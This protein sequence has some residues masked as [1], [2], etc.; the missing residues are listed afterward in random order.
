MKSF[1]IALALL[2]LNCTNASAECREE[3]TAGVDRSQAEFNCRNLMNGEVNG[4]RNGGNGSLAYCRCM[5]GCFPDGNK[6]G[7]RFNRTT[8]V[9]REGARFNCEMLQKGE[10]YNCRPVNPYLWSCDCSY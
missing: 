10:A 7:Q 5:V 9:N 3:R 1:L 4:C 8:G 2:A 6:P